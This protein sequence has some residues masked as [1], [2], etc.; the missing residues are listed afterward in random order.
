[1]QQPTRVRGAAY[2]QKSFFLTYTKYINYAFYSE[3][4]GLPYWATVENIRIGYTYTKPSHQRIGY[5]GN[6]ACY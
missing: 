2:Q 3:S 6:L 4:T 1:M 5:S